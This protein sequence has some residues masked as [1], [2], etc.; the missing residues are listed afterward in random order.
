MRTLAYGLQGVSVDG[1]YSV[2]PTGLVMPMDVLLSD[3]RLKLLFVVLASQYLVYQCLGYSRDFDGALHLTYWPAV[4]FDC[5]MHPKTA[6]MMTGPYI[7]TMAGRLLM[8][9]K[10]RGSLR[11]VSKSQHPCK[12][13][14]V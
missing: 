1:R 7:N 12:S 14:I 2:L 9:I 3:G 10:I 4:L 8:C 6:A 11:L 5:I 13:W